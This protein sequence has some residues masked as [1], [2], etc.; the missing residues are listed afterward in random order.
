MS[1][2]PTHT[3]RYLSLPSLGK[4][5]RTD[6]W[7]LDKGGMSR[8]LEYFSNGSLYGI[9]PHHKLTQVNLLTAKQDKAAVEEQVIFQ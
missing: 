4:C 8:A 3:S 2:L 9:D 7:S 1:T 6:L 5:V